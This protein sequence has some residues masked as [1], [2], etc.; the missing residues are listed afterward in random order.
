MP[1][2]SAGPMDIATVRP[3]R[4][5]CRTTT[6]TP[7]CGLTTTAEHRDLLRAGRVEEPA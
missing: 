6:G 7:V 5:P 1:V 4:R 3:S 2:A